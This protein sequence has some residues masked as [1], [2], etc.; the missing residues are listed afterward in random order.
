MLPIAGSPSL[1]LN[2]TSDQNNWVGFSLRGT[3]SNQDAIGSKVRIEACGR[4]QFES[5]G[6]GGSYLS[7]NDSR[8]H[9]GLGSCSAIAQVIVTW[10]NGM[11]QTIRKPA[12]N[13]YTKFCRRKIVN[14]KS[15]PGIS[16]SRLP[17][18][19]PARRR[20]IRAR[21]AI[22]SR[23]AVMG[24]PEWRIPCLDRKVNPRDSSLMLCRAQH[25]LFSPRQPGCGSRSS[26]MALKTSFRLIM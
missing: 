26:A 17:C 5:V 6:N 25:F 13:R 2:R 15:D 22:R 7:R 16:L 10:P 19:P 14:A 18:K 1:L 9:F 4:T 23:S 21:H 8:V 11:K 24:R 3:R 20:R 12:V